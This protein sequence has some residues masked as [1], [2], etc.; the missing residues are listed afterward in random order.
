M[1]DSTTFDIKLANSALVV[2]GQFDEKDQLGELL[3]QDRWINCAVN[4][5]YANYSA[6]AHSQALLSFSYAY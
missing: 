4:W 3:N 2:S 6:L 1:S 5:L